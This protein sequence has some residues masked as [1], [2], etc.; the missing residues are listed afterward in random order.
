[1]KTVRFQAH[2]GVSTEFPENTLSA[3]R[4]AATQG[5]DI[6]E[7]DPAFTKDGVFVLL[8]D[9]TID[10]TARLLSDGSAPSGIKISD[11]TY[12]EA[13]KY[14]YGTWFSEKFRGEAIPTLESVLKL[15]EDT[16]VTLKLDNKIAKFPESRLSELFSMI[17]NSNAKI[18]FTAG[19]TEFV[20]RICSESARCEIHYDGA[21]SEEIL[22]ELKTTAGDRSLTVWL[23][24]DNGYTAFS[25]L[26]KA[27]TAL[28]ELVKKYARLG[29]WL[30]T[31]EGELDT[32]VN[33]FGASVIETNGV[34]KPFSRLGVKADTHTHTN[35][36]HD[37]KCVIDALALSA[38]SKGIDI[39]TITNH[40]DIMEHP[41]PDAVNGT[42]NSVQDSISANKKYGDRVKILRGAEIGEG[43]T[44]PKLTEKILTMCG[45]D[46]I[47][48]S[49]HAVRWRG[50]DKVYYSGID[51]SAFSENELHEYLSAYFDDV[52]YMLKTLPC[53]IMAHLTC[54]LRYINGKYRRGITLEKHL[55]KITQILRYII[56]HGIAMEINT[57]GIGGP[58]GELMPDTEIIKLYHSLGG[59]LIT[60]GSDS[61][62]ESNVGNGFDYLFSKLKELGI[63]EY[64]YYENRIPMQCRII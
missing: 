24:Y 27:D 46:A 41:H 45:Y 50:L 12:E 61:H 26:A 32:S 58:F 37:S 20:K 52:L 13:S 1:M 17:N 56:K 59:Y 30:I 19:N 5:Y 57:S 28:C 63:R 38:I 10:R 44:D 29:I 47:I 23:P 34:L 54:P 6:I 64:Y 39:I 43:F 9:S 15:S 4:A 2:R 22:S 14:D 55:E 8:H 11:I 49:S 48:G 40:C 18:A 35:R 7:L 62:T 33:L 25:P 42:Y 60:I 21:V 16:G 53:D 31:D 36:S 51:F 3:F